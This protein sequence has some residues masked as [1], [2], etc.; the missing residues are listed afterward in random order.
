MSPPKPHTSRSKRS[1]PV[2]R[3]L[4]RRLAVMFMLLVAVMVFGM[5]GYRI[6]EG[7][8][9]LES[10]YLTIL[11]ISTLGLPIHPSTP[12]ATAFTIVL[13]IG[14]I[15]VA[16]YTGGAIIQ[17]I[18]SSEF[19]RARQRGKVWH[20]MDKMRNH[21]IVCGYG[22]SGRRIAPMLA[23]QGGPLRDHRTGS[24][25]SSRSLKKRGAPPCRAT[26]RTMRCSSRLGL[27]ESSGVDRRGL[28]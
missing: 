11:V 9:W 27:A 25:G 14:G 12:E 17:L 28:H 10:A 24:R 19:Q 3:E 8:S 22:R 7:Q 4:R 23:D 6:L 20:L 21:M 5:A 16:F 18:V 2:F 15:A 26:P 13:A 1:E